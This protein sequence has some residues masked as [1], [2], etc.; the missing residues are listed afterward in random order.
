MHHKN[1]IIKA[2]IGLGILLPLSGFSQNER[3]LARK[4][5]TYY[6]KGK[7]SQA[8]VKYKKSLEK[9]SD[10]NEA[11]FNL[12]NALIRQERYKQAAGEFREVTQNT[13]QKSVKAKAYHN[14]G[15]AFLK[16]KKYRKSVNA[17]KNALRN[18]PQD[19]AT[20]YNLSYALKK[21]RQQ[22]KKQKQKNKDQQKQQNKQKKNKNQ[23]NKDQKQN[24]QKQDQQQG[25]NNKQKKNKQQNQQQKGQQN[26]KQNQ[27]KKGQQQQKRKPQKGDQ[28]KGERKRAQKQQG[29]KEEMSLQEV[30]QI[31]RAIQSQEKDV[32]RK[33][34]KRKRKGVPKDESGK[35]WW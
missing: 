3:S 31:L 34:L 4:G 29:K 15:N 30:N 22:Q 1:L 26:K 8:E 33:V 35:D 17:Y 2:F 32:Q 10:F 9:A 23:Q 19:R 5:N 6:K 7:Y 18:N 12:G 14:M 21:L 25:K 28:Q 16:A 13:D 20:Q 27:D 11:K 24:Q